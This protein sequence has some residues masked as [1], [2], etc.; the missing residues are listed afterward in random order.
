MQL[1]KALTITLVA[2]ISSSAWAQC[3]ESAKTAQAGGCTQSAQ[4]A[5][6]KS[7]CCASKSQLAGDKAGCCASKLASGKLGTCGNGK[8]LARA[9]PAMRYQVGEK[10]TACPEE[11]KTLAAEAQAEIQY[12]VGEKTIA[13][14]GEAKQ[15]YAAL[16]ATHLEEMTTV[17][18]A[19]G[20]ECVACPVTA[21]SMAKKS[22]KPMQFRLASYNFEN[23]D[24]AKKAAEAAR[25]AADKVTMKMVV[26]GKEFCCATTAATVAKA[27]GKSVEYCV[28]EK[29]TACD[30]T[31]S[32]ELA[33][34]K[35]NA[36]QG[37]LDEAMA[38]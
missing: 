13:T 26:G 24:A 12:V 16:L 4:L 25:G 23:E 30:V 11:A 21:K 33:L 35:I 8:T 29:R 14:E 1:R 18:F 10:T 38:G 19:V 6:E 9:I 28:G 5:S 15:A 34:A 36:A 17:K 20:D 3:Q 32:V 2:T 37:A 31:A 22:G 7:G 27:D